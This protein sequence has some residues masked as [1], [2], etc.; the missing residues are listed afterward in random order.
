[1]S[2]TLALFD[3]DGTL[4]RGDSF[5]PFLNDV[6]GPGALARSAAVCSPWLLGYAAGLVGNDVAKERLLKATIRGRDADGLNRAG[7]EF[8]RDIVPALLRD[9]MMARLRRHRDEGRLCVLV[10]ASLDL[11]L[12]PWARGAGFDHVICSRLAFDDSGRATGALAGGN[13]HGAEKVA[14]I[15]AWLA[16]KGPIGHSVA[17]GDTS[18]DAPMLAMADEGFW[19]RRNGVFPAKG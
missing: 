7:F 13:C 6:I 8:A 11:Y 10:S 3:F 18:G 19:V 14:R 9:D 4:T 17:Y 1:V 2:R 5:I 12:K 16:D 15:R